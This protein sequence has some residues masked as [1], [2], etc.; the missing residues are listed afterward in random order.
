M[1]TIGL[2]IYLQQ[3]DIYERIIEIFRIPRVTLPEPQVTYTFVPVPDDELT[4]EQR[5]IERIMK[6]RPRPGIAGTLRGEE[7]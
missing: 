2:I 6:E 4:S 5:R 3:P 1:F 7:P